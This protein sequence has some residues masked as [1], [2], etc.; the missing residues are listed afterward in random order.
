MTG[1]KGL[2]T[3]WKGITALESRPFF[4][5][6]IQ[7]DSARKDERKETNQGKGNSGLHAP[8]EDIIPN[9]KTELFC[10]VHGG[11]VAKTRYRL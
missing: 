9:A 11:Y 4:G 10:D 8:H 3:S 6:Y 1:S 7:T 5:E 2:A